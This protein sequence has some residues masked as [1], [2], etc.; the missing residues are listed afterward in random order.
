MILTPEQRAEIAKLRKDAAEI[1][2]KLRQVRFDLRKD[3]EDLGN[4]L[5]FINIGL[6]AGIVILVALAIGWYRASRRRVH[7][8]E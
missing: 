3:V 6:M 4:K 2:K 1:D 5:K 7:A 8:A